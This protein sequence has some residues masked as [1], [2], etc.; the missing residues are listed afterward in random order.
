MHVV[1]FYYGG[2]V[3]SVVVTVTVTVTVTVIRHVGIG[4]IDAFL[5]RLIYYRWV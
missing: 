1:S 4:L 5:H 3:T 2:G